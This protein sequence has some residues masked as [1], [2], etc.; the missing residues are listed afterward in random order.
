M[1]SHT[2]DTGAE[3]TRRS[4]AADRLS[5]WLGLLAPL[6]TLGAIWGATL[7]SP[8]FVWTVHPLSAL[9][10]LEGDVATETTRTVFNGGL[11]AGAVVGAGFA[12]ALLRAARNRLELAGIGL[13]GPTL[14]SMGA[15]GVFPLPTAFHVPVATAFFGLLTVALFLYG[16]GN[17]VAGARVRG[18]VTLL[19]ASGHGIMW[20]GWFG[21]G[22]V[23]RAGIALPELVGAL[24]FAGW[25]VGTALDVANRLGVALVARPG[26]AERDPDGAG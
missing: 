18:R 2:T 5:C 15:I 21:T 4:R 3:R 14:A 6:V 17:A 10:A 19:A 11:I 1:G 24:V 22:P 7:L 23:L 20:L 26:R 8:S 13:F 16:A 9:G 25:A 12:Y